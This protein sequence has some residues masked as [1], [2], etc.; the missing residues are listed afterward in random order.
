MAKTKK[1]PLEKATFGKLALT[2]PKKTR[3]LSAAVGSLLPETSPLVTTPSTVSSRSSTDCSSASSPS[4]LSAVSKSP[5]VSSTTSNVRK[6][7]VLDIDDHRANTKIKYQEP[8]LSSLA[9]VS[10]SSSISSTSSKARKRLVVDIVDHHANTKLKY[11]EPKLAA[12]NVDWFDSSATKTECMKH[13]SIKNL[14]DTQEGQLSFLLSKFEASDI[15][16][17]FADAIGKVGK[18]AREVFY[19][20]PVR[21]EKLIRSFLELIFDGKSIMVDNSKDSFRYDL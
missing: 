14:P 13:T 8:K 21:K 3:K 18:A 11:Q 12:Y 7:L 1:K 19:P 9:A 15:K 2:T 5:S 17:A 10:K 16:T 6:R 20:L 4:S